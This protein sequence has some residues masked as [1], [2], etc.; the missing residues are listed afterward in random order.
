MGR[1]MVRPP[2]PPGQLLPDSP[3]DE[4]HA[5]PGAAAGRP[6]Y[7]TRNVP[8]QPGVLY[9]GPYRIRVTRSRLA[10]DWPPLSDPRVAMELGYRLLRDLDTEAMLVIGVDLAERI[11]FVQELYRGTV[12]RI[13]TRLAEVLRMAVIENA[14]R[15]VVIHNHPC[16]PPLPS[17][18][19]RS[20]LEQ[21]RFAG[22]ALGITILDYQVVAT[23]PPA[24]WS[25]AVGDS[26]ICIRSESGDWVPQPLP[27]EPRSGEVPP[28][29][30]PDLGEIP[31]ITRPRSRGKV[32]PIA[33][34]GSPDAA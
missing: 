20:L 25:A 22:A 5:P 15:V 10:G 29:E 2:R 21:L 27:A 6:A 12:S 8:L 23:H 4:A 32:E 11:L 9:H 18:E 31:P 26:G 30:L 1:K 34:D 24:A 28:G 16:G 17:P 3:P 13:T 33:A 7:G 14:T 19:D